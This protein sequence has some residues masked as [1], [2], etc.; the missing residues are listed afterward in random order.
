MPATANHS[1]LAATLV[2]ALGHEPIYQAI[3]RDARDAGHRHA[4]LQA[5]FDYSMEE[6]GRLGRCIRAADGQAGVA[7]WLLP[8]DPR[9]EAEARRAKH[10]F[11]DATLGPVGRVNYAAVIDHLASHAFSLVDPATWYLSIIGVTPSSQGAG[12]GA[13]LL[14][15]TLR[16]ADAAGAACYLES[17]N[18][19]NVRFY[20]RHGFAV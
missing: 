5:Y 9:T 14:Q 8:A 15:P 13:R 20:E 12:L 7:V 4:M 16:E 2:S 3:T 6:G 1:A 18:S 11:L 19:R 17:F 10:H